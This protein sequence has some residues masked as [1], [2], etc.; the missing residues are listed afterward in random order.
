MGENLAR[1]SLQYEQTIFWEHRYDEGFFWRAIV[2]SSATNPT[3]GRVTYASFITSPS[4][5]ADDHANTRSKIIKSIRTRSSISRI[6]PDPLSKRFY[7]TWPERLWNP[8][9]TR[10]SP[11]PPWVSAL[12]G[13]VANRLFYASSTSWRRPCK[14]FPIN[15]QVHH[16]QKTVGKYEW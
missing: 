14:R 10:V 4:H 5:R 2:E 7:C 3:V 9:P 13:P 8:A 16:T 1:D 6:Y 12:F 11:T 15:H